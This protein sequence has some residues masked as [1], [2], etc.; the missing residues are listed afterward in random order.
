MGSSGIDLVEEIRMDTDATMNDFLVNIFNDLMDIEEKCLIT[1]EF[2]N[3]SGNDM[4]I[5]HAIGIDDPKRMSEIAGKMNVTTGTLTKAIEALEQKKY[6]VRSRSDK[7]K[8]VVKVSLTDAGV[9]AY[10]HHARF[11]SN[12]IRDVK[13]TLTEEETKLLIVTLGKLVEF[14]HGKYESYIKNKK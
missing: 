3:I 12:M 7:D 5:I 6:V 9:R 10:E 2:M 13:E 11:H 8:R 14:F 4:H 1:G